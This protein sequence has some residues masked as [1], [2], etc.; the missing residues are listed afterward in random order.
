VT[1]TRSVGVDA[2]WLDDALGDDD[3]DDG[4]T[5]AF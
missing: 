3:C 1:K 2:G 4:G 5:D